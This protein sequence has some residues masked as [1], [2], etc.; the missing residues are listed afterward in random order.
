M[1]PV[2]TN[3]AA[4]VEHAYD[5][6]MVRT[7]LLVGTLASLLVVLAPAC[8][9]SN[10][11]SA[12]QTCPAGFDAGGSTGG[13]EA[14][15]VSGQCSNLLMGTK[16]NGDACQQSSECAP[17]CC[18]CPSGGRSAQVAWCNA[19]KCVVGAGVCCAWIANAFSDAGPSVCSSQ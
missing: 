18:A 9:N 12:G 2:R 8:S 3:V 16:Q 5:R 13:T 15:S 10:G 1:D 19:G 4:I 6:P 14:A 7:P 17:T 11:A